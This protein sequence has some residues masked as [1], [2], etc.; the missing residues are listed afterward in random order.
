MK[1]AF[2]SR[3]VSLCG[4]SVVLALGGCG[5]ESRTPGGTE[6]DPSATGGAGGAGGRATGNT[7]GTAGRNAATGGTGGGGQGGSSATGGS[8]GAGGA[9]S[10]GTGGSPQGGA[11]GAAPKDAGAMDAAAL[12]T[13]AGT[14]VA[15]GVQRLLYVAA[16]GSQEFSPGTV[17]VFDINADHKLL[18]KFQAPIYGVK[19]KG[20]AGMIAHAGTARLYITEYIQHSLVAID[21]KTEKVVYTKKPGGTCTHPDRLTISN[22]GKTLYIPCHANDRVW[23]VNAANGET[24]KTIPFAGRPHN[25]MAGESG[26][27]IFVGASRNPAMMLIDPATNE[28]AKMVGP[29]SA[30]GVRP[31][32]V[33]KT[34]THV[35]ANLV[36]LLGFAVGDVATGKQI[37]ELKVT[38]PP[39]R[40]MYPQARA[41]RHGADPTY[42]VLSHGIAVRPPESKEVWLVD[43]EWGYLYVY[44][45]TSMPPKHLANVALFTDI[46]KPWTD[47]ISRWVSF[48][49]DGKYAYPANRL[50][51]DAENRK[52][53]NVKITGSEKMLEIQWKDGAI[54]AV[55][56]QMG[57]VYK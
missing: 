54:T 17:D 25:S 10:G 7:G 4:F 11:G 6:D 44:D 19:D 43:D 12:S 16:P 57:G 55:S 31:F 35:F 51:V 40:A 41:P 29:F 42:F 2:V 38:V 13:D 9:Q 49:I 39:E 52:L 32:T 14:S 3:I 24:I 50:V 53:L 15:Q 22:D 28:I 56:G 1:S 5:A 33:N 47:T 8:G 46:Q 26:K 20:P 18:R 48:S 36:A 23:I 34:E 37:H 30:L 27:Y 45:I 21:L